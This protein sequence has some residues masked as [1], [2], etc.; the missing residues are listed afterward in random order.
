MLVDGE[1][2]YEV[3]EISFSVAGYSSWSHGKGTDKRNG[4]G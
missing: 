1:E 3:E 2:E 4:V